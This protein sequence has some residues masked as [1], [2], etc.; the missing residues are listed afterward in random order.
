MTIFDSI[1]SIL[2]QILQFSQ[3]I[4]IFVQLLSLFGIVI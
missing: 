4:G 2:D 1:I 3:I